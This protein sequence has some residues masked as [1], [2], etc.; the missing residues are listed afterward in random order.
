MVDT[1]ILSRKV[2]ITT[3]A[4][5]DSTDYVDVYGKIEKIHVEIDGLAS[6]AAD[7][8]ITDNT[9]GETILE[10]TNISADS[11]DYP[12]RQV[13]DTSGS[14]IAGAYDNFY[15]NGPLKIVTAD[16]GNAKTGYV[17]VYSRR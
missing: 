14:G 11:V 12:R 17:T 16:G 8:T 6:G 1:G 5:G 7:V 15:V 3:D 4:S 2:T 10:L 13:D 9:S